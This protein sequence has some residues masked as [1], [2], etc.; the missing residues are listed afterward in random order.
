MSLC[1]HCG[2]SVGSDDR[3]CGQCG[4]NLLFQSVP[5]PPPAP[6]DIP[7]P[8][9]VHPPPGVTPKVSILGNIIGAFANLFASRRPL[10]NVTG[11][12]YERLPPPKVAK[13]WKLIVLAVMLFAG[14][15]L[16]EFGGQAFEIIDSNLMYFVS[17]YAVAFL[18]LLWVYRSDKYEREPFRFVIALF[19]W[20]VFSGILA[21][22]INTGLG[23]FFESMF[24]NSALVAPFV[25]EPLKAL[26]LYWL[27]RHKIWGKEF[28]SPL[29]GVV[30]GF[31]VGLGFFAMEN[32]HYFLN[33]DLSVL[34]M[35]SLLCWGHGVWVAT[36]GLWLAV[37]K[38]RRGRVVIWDIVPG[39]LVAM[40]LHFLWN[41]WTG[42]LGE[43]GFIAVLAQGVHQIWYSRR[44][45]KEALRDD[46]LLGY[47]SGM[48]PVERY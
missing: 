16:L 8:T 22:P 24:G 7:P 21:G 11:V 23:P 40:T 48:A 35:R 6:T 42:F 2:A 45:I 18:F 41:G 38:I 28:N 47:N 37:A 46:V 3:F 4:G 25:E 29:D 36:T 27:V 1:P 12:A 43:I 26:G 32:F 39:L 30:Y 10:V 9:Y 20:G 13:S 34:V 19:A 15:Y 17:T 5:T 31:A 14:F 44:M 33:F